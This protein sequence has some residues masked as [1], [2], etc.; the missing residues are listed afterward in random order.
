MRV[1]WR[2]KWLECQERSKKNGDRN[3][4][5]QDQEKGDRTH[6]E[7]TTASLLVD[8]L[9]PALLMKQPHLLFGSQSRR[10]K[11]LSWGMKG[12]RRH[13]GGSKK[14]NN[15]KEDEEGKEC[16]VRE[17]ADGKD[18]VKNEVVLLSF[19]LFLILLRMSLSLCSSLVCIN[20]FL[21]PSAFDLLLIHFSIPLSCCHSPVAPASN[22]ILCHSFCFSCLLFRVWFLCH[23]FSFSTSSVFLSLFSWLFIHW[24]WLVKTWRFHEYFCSKSCNKTHARERDLMSQKGN[25][26]R[27]HEEEEKKK[28]RKNMQPI[29]CLLWSKKSRMRETTKKEGGEDEHDKR[30]LQP[31]RE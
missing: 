14:D 22:T 8:T 10:N 11:K 9:T 25:W 2:L 16:Q 13:G 4:E 31:K 24:G 19:S 20:S 28:K 18:G 21:F 29:T 6:N 1:V 12:W 23:C 15:K 26:K 5:D 30:C 17:E 7:R 3:Y 27:S